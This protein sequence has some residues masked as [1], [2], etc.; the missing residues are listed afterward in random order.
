MLE[1]WQAHLTFALFV[2]VVTPG[3]GLGPALQAARLVVLLGISFI[4]IDGLS[5]AAYMRSFTDDVA[6]TTL[7]A[8]A[9]VA[10]VRLGLAAP[11]AHAAR[12]Q[13]LILIAALALFLYPTTMGLTYFDPYRLGYNPRPL[14]MVIG[15]LSVALL[16]MRNWLGVCMLGLATLAFSL[17]L[18]PSPN[19]WD[20]LLDPFIAL[21]CC[22]ALIGYFG[23]KLLRRPPAQHGLQAPARP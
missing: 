19:Y 21:Y 2:F 6:I 16:L 13:V 3:F 15:A 5:L 7:V 20:Y 18:K 8:L 12:L 1:L 4:V 23:K 14:I 17:G 10:V 11:L 9:F 22:G